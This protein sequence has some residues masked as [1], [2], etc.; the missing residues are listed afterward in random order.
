V[1][2][3]LLS[4]LLSVALG[5]PGAYLLARYD[6]PGKGLVRALTT[7]PFV[8]PSIIVVLGSCASSATTAC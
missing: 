6:F 3:A 2:Q 5:L 7:V 8:L 4:T 1:L